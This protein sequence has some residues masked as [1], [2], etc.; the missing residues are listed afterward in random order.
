M[1]IWRTER[2]DCDRVNQENME[3][4]S[5]KD[6]VIKIICVSMHHSPFYLEQKE[7]NKW[8]H[9]SVGKVLSK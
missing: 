1:N 2:K 8:R 6:M 9:L 4:S 7:K 3:K 5:R